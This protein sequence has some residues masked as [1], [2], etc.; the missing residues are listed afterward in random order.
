MS[1][2]KGGF[3]SHLTLQQ[4]NHKRGKHSAPD[5]PETS[6]TSSWTHPRYYEALWKPKDSSPFVFH[7][8][9][10]L[11][12]FDAL[13]RHFAG[14]AFNCPRRSNRWYI[15]EQITDPKLCWRRAKTGSRLRNEAVQIMPASRAHH[16]A[17]SQVPGMFSRSLKALIIV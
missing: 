3:S 12:N 8:L 1:E 7:T 11:S 10:K 9:P 15:S 2:K 6:L 16:R 13:R 17:E 14:Y 5:P 4:R